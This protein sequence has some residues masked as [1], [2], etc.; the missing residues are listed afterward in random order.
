MSVDRLNEAHFS[1]RVKLYFKKNKNISI[2]GVEMAIMDI[3]ISHI[4]LHFMY[5][6][7]KIEQQKF[8]QKLDQMSQ[9]KPPIIK[10]LQAVI[11]EQT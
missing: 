5:K 3:I 9:R 8:Q 7:K 2:Y 1:Y 6:N 4:I 10:Y 11:C